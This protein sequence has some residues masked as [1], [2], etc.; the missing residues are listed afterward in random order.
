VEFQIIN[1]TSGEVESSAKFL[2]SADPK[3][4]LIKELA[5]AFNNLKLREE[6]KNKISKVLT[7]YSLTL[8]EKKNSGRFVLS[9]YVE[10]LVIIFGRTSAGKFGFEKDFPYM[11]E[12]PTEKE[13]KQYYA[14]SGFNVAYSDQQI[15]IV[16]DFIMPTIN[17]K[18][19]DKVMDTFPLPG[20]FLEKNPQL[21][22]IEISNPIYHR[23]DRSKKTAFNKKISTH[24]FRSTLDRL[25][26]SFFHEDGN[27]IIW[28]NQDPCDISTIL[29]F[30]RMV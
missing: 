17:S 1:S 7:P 12:K 11:A 29:H 6:F 19:S 18:Y 3:Y 16:S 5:S 15:S 28:A 4:L 21:H 27:L 23:I 10:N 26:L 14:Q 24:I 25:H 2:I 13:P 30:R 8:S 9:L 20:G 22:M